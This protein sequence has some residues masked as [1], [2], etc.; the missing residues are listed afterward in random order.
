MLAATIMKLF[1][2]RLLDCKSENFPITFHRRSKA[3]IFDVVLWLVG[4]VG[5]WLLFS[6]RFPGRQ[7]HKVLLLF[8][9]QNE[10]DRSKF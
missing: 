2:L 10:S 8:D 6:R 3:F 4:G 5:G 7:L 1:N 9:R